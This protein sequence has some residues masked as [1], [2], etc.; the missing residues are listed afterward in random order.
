ME[1]GSKNRSGVNTKETN[2]VVPVYASPSTRPRCLVYLLDLY[3]SKLPAGSKERD[4]FCLRPAAG[5]PADPT[6]PRY[7]RAPVGKEKLR[8]FVATMCQEAGIAPKTNHSLRATGA[9]AL[10]NANVPE[11]MIRDVT[12]HCS[13]LLQLYEHPTLQQKQAVPSVLVQ[14]KPTMEAG[15]ENHHPVP[16]C[17]A[18]GSST[19]LQQVRSLTEFSSLFSGLSHC[20]FVVNVG[21]LPTAPVET[22]TTSTSTDGGSKNS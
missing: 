20:N 11:N 7:E 13:N 12:G 21:A 22:P 16:I 15:K 9:T 10:F 4:V 14:G 8:T 2:P 18:P 6:A 19:Q 1:N 5:V 17:H 3:L